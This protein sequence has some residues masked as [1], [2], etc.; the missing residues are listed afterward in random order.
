V[1]PP[2]DIGA[3]ADALDGLLADPARSALLAARGRRAAETR[4]SW[5][6]I[7]SQFEQVYEQ[8]LASR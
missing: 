3:L 7:A 1:V 5:T 8:T 2:N 6:A 4:F